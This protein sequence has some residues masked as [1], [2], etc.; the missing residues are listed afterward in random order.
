LVDLRRSTG[1]GRTDDAVDLLRRLRT[2]VRRPLIVVGDR[3]SVHR[4]AE[5]VVAQLSWK[6]IG[7]KYVPAYAPELNPVEA[8]GSHAKHAQLANYV[9]DDVEELDDSVHYSL[10]EQA[11][12][13]QL[14]L[15]FLKTAQLKL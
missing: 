2:K 5:K 3:W 6:K 9:P 11:R 14:K 7:F 4:A 1:V 15:S 8:M 12:G 10:N 13:H